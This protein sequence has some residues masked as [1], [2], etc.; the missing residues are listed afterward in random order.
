MAAIIGDIFGLNTVY[1]KQSQNV[2]DKK[3]S[4]WPEWASYGYATAGGPSPT[5]WCGIYRLDFTTDL[6]LELPT[7]NPNKVSRQGVLSTNDYGYVS[8]GALQSQFD[9]FDF[10]T[11]SFAL[12]S[13][14]GPQ[15]NE[16]FPAQSVDKGYLC[17]G[18]YSTIYYNTLSSFDF[19]SESYQTASSAFPGR[20]FRGGSTEN[21]F[22]GFFG[23]GYGSP[24]PPSNY[25]RLDFSNDSI[26]QLSTT[27]SLD[28]QTATSTNTFSYFGFTDS[29]LERL[30]TSSDSK[31]IRSLSLTDS[32]GRTNPRVMGD[33][34]FAFFVGGYK[35]PVL[36]YSYIDRFD[37]S[38]ESI[39]LLNSRYGSSGQG[40]V[41]I[42]GRAILKG[43]VSLSNYGYFGGGS[44]LSVI[45]LSSV[46]RLDFQTE[47]V[48]SSSSL[49]EGKNSFSS[50][51]SGDY[52]YFGGGG[53]FGS[54][55]STTNIERLDLS[56]GTSSIYS[57]LTSPISKN[58]SVYS[59]KSYV[60]FGGGYS[61]G[62]IISSIQR[63][64]VTTSGISNISSNLSSE[65]QSQDSI[66]NN[67][68]GYFG[69]GSSPLFSS[70]DRFEFS[71]ETTTLS[72]SVLSTSKSNFAATSST[73]YGYF[74]GGSSPSKISTID[75]FEF[76]TETVTTP[77]SVLSTSKNY[78]SAA[79]SAYYG[80]FGGGYISG[81]F[82]S[83]LD[84][85]DFST[86]TVTTP[87]SKLSLELGLL[88]GVS[89]AS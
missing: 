22:Y 33:N 84:R 68:Y 77:S 9:R 37:Y 15:N 54:I 29:T 76:S 74:A 65:R 73:S 25:D 44:T 23:G 10:T 34:R 70:I 40:A 26:K 47:T 16:M 67:L 17:M 56:D 43:S 14:G 2:F 86:E 81:S 62:S 32:R 5:T 24:T 50:S 13:S 85:L 8:R 41:T 63:L 48:S 57:S 30:D 87:S 6:I 88:S 45:A 7:F 58:S 46:D 79:S 11:E 52:G 39:N 75:R 51:S 82:I 53:S 55:I 64:D 69:G 31:D 59:P 1:Q 20:K 21:D 3:I 27:T 78:L 49:K 89:S 71:S 4:G 18:Q 61:D 38:T 83:T 12:I 42:N 60:Y 72:S 80:Y 66:S 36:Y 19:S 28:N 35:N